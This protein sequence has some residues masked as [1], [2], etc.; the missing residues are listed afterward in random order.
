MYKSESLPVQAGCCLYS[1][2]SKCTNICLDLS[3]HNRS[4]VKCIVSSGTL[5]YTALQGA[6]QSVLHLIGC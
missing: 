2:F 1:V 4:R 5:A 3:D 6:V